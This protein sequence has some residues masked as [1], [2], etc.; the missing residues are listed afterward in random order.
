[1]ATASGTTARSGAPWRAL[2][3]VTRRDEDRVIAG[4]CSGIAD[5]LDADP[6]VVR[7]A[8]AI[9]SLASG[10]GIV[11]Y[12]GAWALLPA[13]GEEADAR[14]RRLRAVGF[15]LLVLGALLGM[16]GLGLSDSVLWPTALLAG[17]AVLLLRGVEVRRLGRP[18]APRVLLGLTLL[19]SGAV[20]FIG[21]YQPF[22][23][24]GGRPIAPGVVAVGLGLVVAPWLWRLAH[25][26]LVERMARIRA[27]ERAEVA[28]RVH[29]SVLQT[30]ALIQRNADDPRRVAS[31]ARQEERELRH[32]LYPDDARLEGETL[33]STLERAALE[34]EQLHDVRID[35]VGSG[36][37]R[38]EDG[39]DALVLA[40]REAMTNAAK[41][42]GCETISVY[43]ETTDAGV[44]VFVRDR[45]VGFDRK[46][47]PADRRGIVESIEGR[48]QRHGGEATV[49]SVPGEGTEVELTMK[50]SEP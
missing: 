11:L 28:A 20:L 27:E 8:F 4:V 39:L 16:R 41:F 36:D 47:V 19:V 38:V 13:P 30:L 17:G 23:A 26:R 33:M 40:A 31:L 44:S 49:S 37:C 3:Q 32:W 9:L 14:S 48:M 25:D 35:I 1:M 18:F 6:T 29:D 22:G 50:R 42:S 10:S 7:L 2:P 45:G 34:V 43:A 46:A 15:G 21:S 12:L 5:A 24:S